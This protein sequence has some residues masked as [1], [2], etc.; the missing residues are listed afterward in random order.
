MSLLDAVM[1]AKVEAGGRP[2]RVYVSDAGAIALLLEIHSWPSPAVLGN[3]PFATLL[4]LDWYVDPE[5]LGDAFR[6]EE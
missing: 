1:L 4:G 6:L 3:R 5:L 2:R